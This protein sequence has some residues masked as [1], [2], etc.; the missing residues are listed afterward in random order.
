MSVRKRNLHCT[1]AQCECGSSHRHE[2]LFIAVIMAL[3][4]ILLY[5]VG[6]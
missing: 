5:V 6:V 2:A 3:G 1:C 4:W